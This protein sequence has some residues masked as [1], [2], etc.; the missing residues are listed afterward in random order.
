MEQKKCCCCGESIGRLNT[1]I[2][3]FHGHEISVCMYCGEA[4]DKIASGN[5]RKIESGKKYLR[6]KLEKNKATPIGIPLIQETL[7]ETIDAD[8]IEKVIGD[9]PSASETSMKSSEVSSGFPLF[10]GICF[11]ISSVYFYFVSTNNSHGVANIPSTIFSAAS[12]VSAI[13]SFGTSTIIKAINS[14]K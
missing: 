9:L 5:P 8:T 4:F 10:A 11:L 2:I 1:S 13:V 3:P 14:K 12:F 6:A 7:G